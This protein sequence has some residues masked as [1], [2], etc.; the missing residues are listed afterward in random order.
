MFKQ[1]TLNRTAEV[2]KDGRLLYTTHYAD[3]NECIEC[4]R[5]P[6]TEQGLSFTQ[7]TEFRN[8]WM[9]A[10]IVRHSSGES[11]ESVMPIKLDGLTFQQIGSQLTYLKRYQ[12]AAFFGLA[13]DFDDDGNGAEGNNATFGNG[14]GSHGQQKQQQAPQQKPT[15]PPPKP[16]DNPKHTTGS[17]PPKPPT[18]P[19]TKPVEKPPTLNTAPK[20][21]STAQRTKIEEIAAKKAVDLVMYLDPKTI[22]M[23]SQQEAYNVIKSLNEL[24]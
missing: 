14:K 20:S 5:V 22:E 4:V 16:P 19:D 2:K 3:L 8:G 13:A 11:L 7:G 18:T 12:F 17:T 21:I 6:L 15:N 1:P 10:L 24:K 23:L 9:L